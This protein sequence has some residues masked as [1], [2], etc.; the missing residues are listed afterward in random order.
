MTNYL[1]GFAIGCI[2]VVI[3]YKVS[4]KPDKKTPKELTDENRRLTRENAEYKIEI[5]RNRTALEKLQD[6]MDTVELR[7]NQADLWF[8]SIIR[9]SRA[10]FDRQAVENFLNE[11]GMS[12]EE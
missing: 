7:Q 5:N 3:G 8:A 12:E 6:R 11:Q 9:H 10:Q 2:V 4:F 1:I